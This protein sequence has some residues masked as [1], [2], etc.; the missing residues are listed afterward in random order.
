MTESNDPLVL[1]REISAIL[2]KV[3][4]RGSLLFFHWLIANIHKNEELPSPEEL[5]RVH[6]VFIRVVEAF[7][8]KKKISASDWKLMFRWVATIGNDVD[9]S[10]H[11]A[12][13]AKFYRTKAG[14]TRLQ[15]AKKLRISLKTV[16]ALERGGIK[17]MSLPRLLQLAD[18]LSVNA[19][20]F[21]DRIYKLEQAAEK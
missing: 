19:G 17:D 10:R 12:S 7:R 2:D 20:E 5:K 9:I 14:L 6:G 13:T 16:L 21:M 4:D 15:L 8:T 11:L 1:R 3:T 18:A